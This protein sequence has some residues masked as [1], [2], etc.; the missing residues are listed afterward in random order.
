MMQTKRFIKLIFS[1]IMIL[2]LVILNTV[3]AEVDVTDEQFVVEWGTNFTNLTNISNSPNGAQLP[4]IAVAPNGN[5]LMVV[6][7]HR[8]SAIA[9]NNDPYFVLSNNQGTTWTAPNDIFTSNGVNSIQPSVSFDNL[10]NAH[11]VW[12]EDEDQILYMPE[13]AW[14]GSSTV[15]ISD[16]PAN[17]S[18]VDSPE[19]IASSSTVLDVV[20]AQLDT[21]A[22][23]PSQNIFHARSTN[24]GASWNGGGIFTV[25]DALAPDMFIDSNGNIHVVWQEN[26]SANK[27]RIMYTRSTDGGQNWPTAIEISE[28]DSDRSAERPSIIKKNG[29]L[30]VIYTEKRAGSTASALVDQS[31]HAVRCQSSCM[32]TASWTDAPQLAS[33][34]IVGANTN[35]SEV[36]VSSMAYIDDCTLVAFHG[37][38]G[39]VAENN[40]IVFNTSNCD[41]SWSTRIEVSNENVRSLRP[42]IATQGDNIYL[43]F[44]QSGVSSSDNQI[45][46]V[47][48][49]LEAFNNRTIYLPMV[50]NGN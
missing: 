39:G 28:T 37:T 32:S 17:I 1:T 5:R 31:I 50:D 22:P 29:T 43:V 35:N 48:G 24:G 13:S 9:S 16:D 23:F 41:G 34:P 12:V 42:V 20:W 30:E 4:Q 26:L 3:N 15:R 8:E 10:N 44:T 36:I 38:V 25:P 14:G 6:F 18:S 40:E 19:I 46:F 27:W 11:A 2:P 47:S 45:K 33:G 21:T 49:Q 7:N